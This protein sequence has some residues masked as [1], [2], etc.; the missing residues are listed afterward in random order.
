MQLD[1]QATKMVKTVHMIE[2]LPKLCTDGC[3]GEGLASY[4][5]N[6]FATKVIHLPLSLIL[7]PHFRNSIGFSSL[8]CLLFAVLFLCLF[9]I[10]DQLLVG[11]L[12]FRSTNH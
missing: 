4:V 9:P 10:Q 1:M 5:G 11:K 6:P 3:K 8:V 12:I 7:H 2:M